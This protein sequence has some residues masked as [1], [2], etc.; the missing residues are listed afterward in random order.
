MVDD[1]AHR[2]RPRAQ[3]A[4]MTASDDVP[5]RSPAGK[6]PQ[7]VLAWLRT[8]PSLDE[9]VAAYPHEWANVQRSIGELV[10]AGDTVGLVQQ[11]RVAQAAGHG[12]SD[13][14][15]TRA[16]LISSEVRRQ[17][18]AEAVR[19]AQ[20]V[21]AS[22]VTQGTVRFGLFSGWVLQR[23]LFRKA[24]ERRPVDIRLFRAVWPLVRQRSRLM[25]LVRPQ[26]IYCFYSRQLVD[27]LVGLLDGRP[28]VEIA[29]GDGTLTRFLRDRGADVVATDDHSWDRSITYPDDVANESARE[30]LIRRQPR[31]VLCSWPPADNEFER[32]V[33]RTAS[34]ELYVVLSST[35]EVAA[36]SW[37]DY[38]SQSDFDLEVDVAL[39][40]LLLPPETSPAVLVF[41]RRH[42]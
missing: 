33:F 26:G 18:T 22:G 13:R 39:G 21:Q 20:L 34:V 30:S 6:K 19:R 40:R 23:L 24:L 10:A 7:D 8:G 17:M 14:R 1:L 41:R 9:L 36:G 12:P 38:R 16:Q 25:P 37:S 42:D 29:A 32:Q 3:D 28:A 35:S 31:V 27:A 11:L 4:A 2:A 15:P 5:A